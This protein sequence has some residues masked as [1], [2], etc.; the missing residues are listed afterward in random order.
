ML[1]LYFSAAL[2]LLPVESGDTITP[3]PFRPVKREIY[4]TTQYA[5]N[6]GLISVGF[7][8]YFFNNR[9]SSDINYGFL[10]EYLNGIRVHSFS[11]KPAYNFNGFHFNS[12]TVHCY[13]GFNLVYSKGK[14][15]YASAPD[16]YPRDY[17]PGN[18]FHF[19]PFFGFKQG[20]DINTGKIRRISL[21]TELGT[22]DYKIWYAIK[23]RK[24]TPLEILNLSL[25]LII[26]LK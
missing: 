20:I 26:D 16:H 13:T 15:I 2:M 8:S 17:Y 9:I 10:P 3:E 22:V 25:G 23:N 19:N 14:N 24:I 6:M 1:A 4:I 21:F 18:A 11:I 12:Y 7:G 5:G